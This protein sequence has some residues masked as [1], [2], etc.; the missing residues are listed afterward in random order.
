MSV[1]AY[2]KYKD[3]GV[4]WLGKVPDHWSVR[5]LKF[6]AQLVT[7]KAGKKS[8]PV[9][10][11]NIESWSGRYLP[12]ESEFEGDGV[13][14]QPNDILFGKLRPYLAKALLA[15][16]PGE[17]VGDFHVFRPS[18][19][20]LPK[21]LHYQVLEQKFIDIVDGSTFGSKMPRASWEH[22]GAMPLPLPP[23]AEQLSITE[24]LKKETAKIDAL[25]QEQERLIGLLDED[26]SASVANLLLG[27]RYSKKKASGIEWIGT[28]PEHWH[29]ARVCNM[30]TESTELGGDGLPVLSVSIHDGVSDK[31]LDDDELDRKVTRSEDRGKY[32]RVRSGDLV[33]NMMRAW[34][35]G[36]GSVEVDGLVSP[37]YVVARPFCNIST[38]YVESVLR[39]SNAIVEM[40]SRSRGITDFRLRLYWEEFRDVRIP[41]PP[42]SEQVEILKQINSM[43]ARV[44]GLKAEA[45][46]LI[47]LLTERR[48]ALI[49]SAVTGK[50]DVR[51]QHV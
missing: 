40:K 28:I 3:C 43:D 20:L 35:G 49:S 1:P 39:T 15:T 26:R 8:N 46:K 50:I 5:K 48:L 10:L 30:F 17:A 27:G 23:L 24:F 44:A 21:F 7:E 37:A 36:F 6:S 16:E 38:K 51:G 12:T 42:V 22:V 11:E 31:E 33:Y 2:P 32:K 4:E 9:A 45:T 19:E 25:I 13:S 34:Q 14:F 18:E 47:A 41:V 29:V